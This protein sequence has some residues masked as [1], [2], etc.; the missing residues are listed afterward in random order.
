MTAGAS[1]CLGLWINYFFG[2]KDG[3]FLMSSGGTELISRPIV[4]DDPDF[5]AS[6]MESL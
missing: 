4:Q 3:K 1:I 5:G 6:P 2:V